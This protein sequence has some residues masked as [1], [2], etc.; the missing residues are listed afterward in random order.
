MPEIYKRFLSDYLKFI[1]RGKDKK[2]SPDQRALAFYNAFKIM[3]LQGM[4]LCGT[5]MQP[6]NSR[7]GGQFGAGL[8]FMACKKCSYKPGSGIWRICEEH[9]RVE[10]RDGYLGLG[11]YVCPKKCSYDWDTDKWT[12]CSEHAQEAAKGVLIGLEAWTDQTKIPDYWRFHYRYRAAK[13]AL[14]AGKLA[15]DRELKALINYSAGNMLAN[16]SPQEANIF[17][18]RLVIHGRGTKLAA[19]ADEKRWFPKNTVLNN[20]E[21]ELKYY[22]SLEEI[23]QLMAS[24]FSGKNQT[25]QRTASDS[26]D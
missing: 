3:R 22:H 9:R 10:N 26:L 15:R 20:E 25:G 7:Y 16:R 17:Y 13:I 24:A 5:E 2:L 23:H 1:A 21:K 12:L 8:G 18:K 11:F 14:A 19:A 4:T 6:D